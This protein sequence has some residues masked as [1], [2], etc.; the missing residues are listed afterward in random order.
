M[1]IESEYF[2]FGPIKPVLAPPPG[3]VFDLTSL[4][5]AHLP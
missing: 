3:E 2:D 4:L 1:S 5:L